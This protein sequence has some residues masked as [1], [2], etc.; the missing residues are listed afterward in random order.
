VVVGL[1]R[2]VV[3]M[4]AL[5]AVEMVLTQVLEVQA[6]QILVQVGAVLE[7]LALEELVAMAVQALLS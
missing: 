5:V 7:I 4:E 6:Q 3:E 2:V 1:K